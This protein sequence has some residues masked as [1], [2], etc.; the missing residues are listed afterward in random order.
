MIGLGPDRMASGSGSDSG[1]PMCKLRGMK[2]DGRFT[3]W[4]HFGRYAN[5]MVLTSC[6]FSVPCNIYLNDFRQVA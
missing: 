4:M 3:R 6:R 1:L 5:V 2:S